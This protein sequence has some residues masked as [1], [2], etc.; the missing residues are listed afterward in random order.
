M[1]SDHL[2]KFI[3]GESVL[4]NEFRSGNLNLPSRYL[5]PKGQFCT[6]ECIRI[7]EELISPFPAALGYVYAILLPISGVEGVYIAS[8]ILLILSF[9]LLSILWDWDPLFLGILALT[10]S[11]LINGYFFP[12]VGIASFLFISG[13]YLFLRS[14]P[15]SSFVRLILAGFISVLAAWFRIE[16]IILPLSFIFF[17]WILRFDQEGERRRIR[18]FT[19]GYVLAIGFLFGTQWILYGH[20]LGPRFY[21][22]SPGIFMAPWK[23]LEIF[24]GLLIKSPNRIGFF[25]YSPLFLLALFF[26][27]YYFLAERKFF[28]KEAR[29]SISDR[30]CFVLSGLAAFVVLVFSAPN[31]GIID[32]GTRYL[33]LSIPAFAGMSFILFNKIRVKFGKP[34]IGFLVLILL[35][36]FYVTCLY[37]QILARYGSK[38]TKLNRIYLEQ[39][40]D[41]VVVQIMMY[42]QILGKYYFETP[43]V[44]VMREK[45]I[46]RFFT[47][48]DAKQFRKIMFV[49]SKSHFLETLEG[50]DPFVEN[51]YYNY[52]MQFIGKDFERTWFENK[53]DVLIFSM[54]RKK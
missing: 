10:S 53:E 8:A 32:W 4:R 19:I 6:T 36:S 25:G 18:G 52:L 37:T 20:P 47:L 12:D 26:G 21:Y 49:Q 31:D 14:D 16:S 39:K 38:T 23:K 9:L 43:S 34:G 48:N 29:I 27:V 22:N 33:H 1:Y 15:K 45:N 28:S 46:K 3:L 17:F 51:K 2:G 41:L 42:S 7:G 13:S 30:D 11:F 5:D 40:P 35:F 44:W 50:E 24:M 54:E